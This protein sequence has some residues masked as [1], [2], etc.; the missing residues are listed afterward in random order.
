MGG[1][2]GLFFIYVSWQWDK[3]TEQQDKERREGKD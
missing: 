3:M 1:I 2:Y